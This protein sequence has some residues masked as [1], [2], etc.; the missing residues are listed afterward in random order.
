[1]PAN[2]DWDLWLGPAPWAAYHPARC[3][4]TYRYFM[5]YGGG[6]LADNGVHMFSVVSWALGADQTG[7]VTVAATGR[8]ERKNLY[9]VPV[10]LCVQYEFTDPQFTL[11]WEQSAGAQLNLEFVGS[12]AT[13]SGFWDFQVTQGQADL[14]P[15]RGDELQLERSDSHSG[16]W[17]SCIA[18]RRRPVMDVE[19]GHRVTCWSHLGNLAY[20][21]GRKLHWDPA[22]ERFVGDDEANRLLHA[23]CR[24]PWRL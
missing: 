10:D 16:N 23:A 17:L 1:V 4:F 7:P 11:I 21:L 22:A 3:H 12:E 18:S 14:A 2:L 19:I 24:A 9:D 13:L 8:D 15:T 5:D 20:Q 6:A